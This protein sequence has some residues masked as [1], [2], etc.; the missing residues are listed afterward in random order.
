MKAIVR[1]RPSLFH[2]LGLSN[3]VSTNAKLSM[4]YIKQIMNVSHSYN[5]TNISFGER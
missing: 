5:G 2:D 3:V 4:S 1:P